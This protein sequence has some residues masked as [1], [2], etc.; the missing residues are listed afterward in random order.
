VNQARR[1]SFGSVADLYDRARPSY[2]PATIDDVLAHTP[3]DGSVRA[4]EVGAGT[5]KATALFA[6]RGVEVHAL[7]PSAGMAALARHNCSASPIVTIEQADFETWDPAGRTFDLVFSAQAWHWIEPDQRYP[8]ARAV[9]RPGG[10]LAAFWNRADWSRCELR[11]PLERA[12]AEHAPEL[13]ADGPMHPGARLDLPDLWGR[14]HDEVEESD[15]FERPELRNHESTTSYTT[16]EYLE[17]LQTHSDHIVLDPSHRAA[18]LAAVGTAID[19][20]GGRFT[21][22]YVTRLCLARASRR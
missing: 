11:E 22:V 5:G 20:A 16:A 1:L 2:P 19:V 10:L 13:I 3:R 14:F 4:L 18:L 9:L 15:G 12:Y 21:L 17:L 7:E 8:L 6:E